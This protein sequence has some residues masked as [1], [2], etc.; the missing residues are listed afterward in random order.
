MKLK[1]LV[2][3]MAIA[4][5]AVISAAGT[6]AYAKPGPSG[7]FSSG[8]IWVLTK[9]QSMCLTGES[10]ETAV[11]TRPCAS[12]SSSGSTQEK[13]KKTGQLWELARYG[14]LLVIVWASDPSRCLGNYLGES[15]AELVNCDASDAGG[16]ALRYEE[17]DIKDCPGITPIYDCGLI[18]LVNGSRLFTIISADIYRTPSAVAWGKPS[19]LGDRFT[20]SVPKWI[21]KD[22]ANLAM[23]ARNMTELITTENGSIYEIDRAAKIWKRLSWPSWSTGVRSQGG[24]YRTASSSTCGQPLIITADPL[25]PSADLR[26]ITTS[27]IVKVE[28][29]GRG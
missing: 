8:R 7:S 15:A 27:C 24:T 9:G 18:T 19:G 28:E 21:V 23:A 20:W 17:L 12:G 2:A 13:E 6:A 25:D 29:K 26:L 16:A 5:T 22:A 14:G 10:N 3:A 4:S 11:T 1:K